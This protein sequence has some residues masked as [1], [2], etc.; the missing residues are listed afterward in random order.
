MKKL[1]Y[2][3]LLIV[4]VSCSFE[5]YAVID[6]KSPI[7]VEQKVSENRYRVG[8]YYNEQHYFME[9]ITN[10]NLEIGDKLQLIKQ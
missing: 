8:Y 10:E 5:I 7:I 2:I 6:C 3:L 4:L 1:V 9:I